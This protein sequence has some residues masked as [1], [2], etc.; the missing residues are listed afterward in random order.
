MSRHDP[1]ARR[2]A[3]RLAAH[4][5]SVLPGG[6]AD[7]ALAM[8]HEIDHLQN[9][10][11]ALSWAVGCVFASY[12][13][14]INVMNTTRHGIS[15]WVLGLEMLTCFVWLTG[16]FAAL[17]S[18]GVYGFSGPLPIDT[19]FLTMLFASLPGP[20]GLIVAF[21]FVIL[22]RWTMSKATLAALCAPAAWT[23]VVFTIQVSAHP[24]EAFG[25]WVLLALLPAV[26]VAHLIYLTRPPR[27][28]L[29]TA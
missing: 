8:R 7:W 15:R 16:M 23:L 5:G 10:R 24:L 29:V 13:E 26:G 20:I 11:A 27:S 25:P 17:L 1:L 3:R 2:V 9:S 18:R 22:G 4:A 6:R 14:R 19:W 12:L 28:G 21:K